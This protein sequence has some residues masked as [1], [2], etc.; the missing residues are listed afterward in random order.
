MSHHNLKGSLNRVTN[1]AKFL[2]NPSNPDPTSFKPIVGATMRVEA[3]VADELS[4]FFKDPSFSATTGND[5]SFSVRIPETFGA[6]P[7]NL[8]KNFHL[9][10]FNLTSTVVLGSLQIPMP[11]WIY[12]SAPFALSSLNDATPRRVFVF[13][14]TLSDSD[15]ITQAMIDEHIGAAKAR[16]KAQKLSAGITEKGIQ[17]RFER[18]GS[19]VK[20]D[21]VL[22]PSAS[23][24]L[25]TFIEGSIH[26]LDID[27]PGPDFIT[28]ICKSDDDIRKEFIQPAIDSMM[29]EFNKEVK[30]KVIEEMAELTH[31][32]ES[33]VEAVFNSQA[34]LTFEKLRF[35]VIRT[36]PVGAFT[37]KFRNIVPAL[38][39]GFP[40]HLFK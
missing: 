23:D 8:I 22:S 12:R 31:Q 7:P 21:V 17:V 37:L 1:I 13:A 20:F 38:S 9:S 36:Q 11:R 15:G 25:D 30:K 39:L 5:G 10:A 24:N 4:R 40:R 29:K 3:N 19:V 33:V 14:P 26:N 18:D 34:T 27:R 35:P 2:Q 32:P 28:E 16:A 6:V